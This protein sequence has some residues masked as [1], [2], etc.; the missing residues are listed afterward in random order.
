[1]IEL[2]F[3]YFFSISAFVE[4]WKE[5]TRRY[6]SNYWI[7]PL[8]DVQIYQ[9][10]KLCSKMLRV[11]FDQVSLL[12][13][14][15]FLL[16]RKT[17]FQNTFTFSLR[18]FHRLKKVGNIS[19]ERTSELVFQSSITNSRGNQSCP[20]RWILKNIFAIE[21]YFHSPPSLSKS[22]VSLV[23]LEWS[24]AIGIWNWAFAEFKGTTLLTFGNWVDDSASQYEQRQPQI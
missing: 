16:L 1:M 12:S 17:F 8:T 10:W 19:R 5:R 14:V 18:C 22:L 21:A 9:G 13:V 20:I 2:V 7:L 3:R 23:K 24:I 11:L 4:R 15:Q 6:F